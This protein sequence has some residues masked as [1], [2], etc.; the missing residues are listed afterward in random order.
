MQDSTT[1]FS[2][3]V[4][5]YVKYRP[6]YPEKIVDFLE[7]KYQLST[8]GI[9][10]DIGSG[11][12]ISSKLFLDKNYRVIGIE[13]NRKMS[14]KAEELLKHYNNFFGTIDA[15]AENTGLGN[16]SVDTI[17]AGQAFHWFDRK[18]CKKEFKRI[19]KPNG[20][21]VLMWNERLAESVFE[22][23]YDALIVK[24]GTD[25]T[26]ID[27]RNIDQKIIQDFFYPDTVELKIFSNQQVFDFEGLK[28]RLFSSS[29]A[30]AETDPRAVPMLADLKVLFNKYQINNTIIIRYAT[31]V[32]VARMKF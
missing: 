7:E 8:D 22:K 16:H 2:N 13:P 32:Y 21:V 5:N 17:V 27:H 29:Y 19:I 24:H 20:I 4:D 6:D 28:G 15:T 9:I 12:G 26:Q 31:N 23:E 25:Y 1:R 10:A 3:R 14:E 11:T 18:A 30:P